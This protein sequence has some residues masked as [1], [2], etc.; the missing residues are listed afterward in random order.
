MKLSKNSLRKRAFMILAV[1]MTLIMGTMAGAV[2]AEDSPYAATWDDY[3]ATGAPASTWNDVVD[4][5]ELVLDYGKE[6]YAD[7]DADAAYKAVSN[8]YYGF[9]ETTGFERIAM[10]YIS[11]SR[12]SQMELQFSAAKAVA[13]KG[14]S[15]DDYNA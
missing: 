10:G 4:A 12:K 1:M 9:Y 15:V 3:K 8:A 11:G 5:M 13:K 6:A 14:G 2:Y 7:G